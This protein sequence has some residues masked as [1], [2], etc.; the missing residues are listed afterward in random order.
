MARSG[1]LFISEGTFS[2]AN[3]N[4]ATGAAKGVTARSPTIADARKQAEPLAVSMGEEIA[5]YHTQRDLLM[6][7]APKAMK[8]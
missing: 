6:D 1:S 8:G 5:F 4:R 3:I 2:T 7:I